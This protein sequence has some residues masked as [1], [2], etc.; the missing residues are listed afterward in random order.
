LRSR[1]VLATGLAILAFSGCA[2]YGG[3]SFN[4]TANPDLQTVML[5]SG[6]PSPVGSRVGDVATTAR[7][8][9]DCTDLG[10]TALRQLLADAKKLGGIGVK[11]VQFRGR[12]RWVGQIVCKNGSFGRSLEVRGVAYHLGDLIPMPRPLSVPVPEEMQPQITEAAILSVAA[13]QPIP[14][15]VT[16]YIQPASHPLEALKVKWMETRRS[17]GWFPVSRESGHIVA[18]HRQ[19]QFALRVEVNYTKEKITGRILTSK[20]LGQ[21]KTQISA[22]AVKWFREFMARTEVAVADLAARR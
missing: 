12:S 3:G 18:G 4:Y 10:N 20:N 22:E 19:D 17:K 8:G 14:D 2:S 6:T 16:T 15:W 21:T 9:R 11:D 7:G 5:Y 1:E 13:R